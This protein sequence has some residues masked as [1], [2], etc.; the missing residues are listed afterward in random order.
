M[1]KR[2]TKAKRDDQITLT[3]AYV[4][5]SAWAISFI[6]DIIKPTYDPPTSVHALMMI[7][8]GATFGEGLLRT[9]K[10]DDGPPEI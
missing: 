9:R 4:I 8:A 3:I 1:A 5:T 6:I 10:K 7:V 2:V